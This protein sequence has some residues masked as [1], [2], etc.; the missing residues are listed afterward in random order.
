M[1]SNLT[2]IILTFNEARN[3]K[4]C[5][6]SVHG[7]AEHVL[8]VDSGSTDGTLDLL[9]A[10]NVRVLSHPFDNYSKQR[11]WAQENNPFQTEWVFHLDAGERVS[12]E[13]REWLQNT[14]NS[15]SD[16]DGF[17][18]CRRM[19]FMGKWIKH[20]GL[21]PTY[22]TRLFR[23][24]KGKCEAKAYDQHFVVDGKVCVVDKTVHIV[25]YVAKDLK[26]FIAGHTRWAVIEA[27]ELLLLAGHSGNVEARLQG[28][29]IEQRRWLKNNVFQKTPLFLRSF[30]YFN[31]RYFFRLG[32]L[33][34]RVGLICH[35]LQ[36]FGFRFL[37]D[38]MI[39]EIK[40][41]MKREH[42]A[43][44]AALKELYDFDVDKLTN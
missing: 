32:F 19:M 34:G 13:L 21:Y 31:Y 20:G 1:N 22:H 9:S 25:D 36:G 38:S 41:K 3:I 26:S 40:N 24:C 43:L 28:N 35:L 44:E 17:M 11:N 2:I 4:A 6:D 8:V 33:D 12:N 42:L 7:I 27:T 37:I 23:S 10:C 14:F 16:Y 39:Y 18:F 5:L 15:E 29:P 30:L